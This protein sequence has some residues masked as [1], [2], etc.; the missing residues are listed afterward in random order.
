MKRFQLHNKYL[1]DNRE[2]KR[3]LYTKEIIKEIIN[4]EITASL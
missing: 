4:K 2:K 3:K 1:K